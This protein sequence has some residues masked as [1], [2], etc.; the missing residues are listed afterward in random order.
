MTKRVAGLQVVDP[1]AVALPHG[2]EVT[3]RVARVA[4]DRRVPQGTIARVVRARDAGF[5]VQ[6][7]GIGE[8]WYARDEL[9]PRRSGQ[10]AFALRREAA[11]DALRLNVVLETT[12]G[13]R[14][15]GLA[16]EKSDT[17][18]RGVF[19][20]PLSW[21][22]GLVDPP[23]DLS[24]ADS[25][26][27][28]WELR[29]TIDQA[30]RA[31]PNTLEMLFVP[32]ATPTD[33]LGQWLLDARDAFV[34]KQIFGSFG[35][36]ALSQLDTLERSQRLAEHRDQLLAWLQ[37]EPVPDLDACTQRLAAISPRNYPT[38][39]DAALGAK[40]YIKQLYRSLWDQGLLAQNDFASLVT[41]ARAGGRRPP[42]SRALRPKNAYNL[43]RLIVLATDWLAEGVPRFEAT[44][45]FRARLL[46]IKS[47]AVP[48]E[49]VLREAQEHGPK[50]EA[51]RA[52]SRLP[53]HP[54]VRKAHA[55]AVRVGEEVARRWVAQGPGPFG[56][57]APRPP[58]P[59]VDD[60][61]DR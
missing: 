33:E 51:A 52:A 59:K 36:Y 34:S 5:D 23:S 6:I 20:L 44:G 58:D 11:W 10:V 60:D 22:L 35:R 12:V 17:D 49:E 16:D 15:W 48:L 46:E 28:F 21:T 26:Q 3:T 61:A 43:L 1:V 9:A 27:M 7:I 56:K 37:E 47:G 29:K 25:T 50:L 13:S 32:S 31:D 8:V 39:A 14:A 2:T 38:P 30:L 45:A 4:G 53:E 18:V 42:E 54:D 41:Y 55:L 40:T 19:A 24:S 57:D